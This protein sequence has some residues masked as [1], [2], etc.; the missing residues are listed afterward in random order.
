MTPSF[1]KSDRLFKVGQLNERSYVTSSI[2][3]QIALSEAGCKKIVLGQE[4]RPTLST[5]NAAVVEY[6]DKRNEFALHRIQI[7]VSDKELI[8]IQ[9]VMTAKEAWD[10]IKQAHKVEGTP[11][12]LMLL[13]R[14]TDL[15]MEEGSSAQEYVNRFDSLVVDCAAL[16]LGL[17]KTPELL[18]LFFLRGLSKSLETFAQCLTLFHT[19]EN[20]SRL[21]PRHITTFLINHI[22]TQTSRAD[23]QSDENSAVRVHK[24]SARGH[25]CGKKGHFKSE[26]RRTEREDAQQAGSSRNRGKSSRQ[27][28]NKD[29]TAKGTDWGL[30]ATHKTDGD[31]KS[32]DDEAAALVASADGWILNSGA[33][34]H[35][36]SNK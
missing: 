5:E 4:A 36:V 1:D 6:W 11:G 25:G 33:S 26:C 12:K 13:N 15:R 7:R 19:E 14:L 20:G 22:R 10:R 28:A 30:S 27:E 24:A 9:D 35:I 23:S 31:S 18:A 21:T 34:S 2:R 29:T 32:E 17:D 3:I 16:D 8:A